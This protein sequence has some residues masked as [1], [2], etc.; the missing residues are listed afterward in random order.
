MNWSQGL[1]PAREEISLFV[2]SFQDP[3]S[4]QT[5]ISMRSRQKH[6]SGLKTDQVLEWLNF[7][8]PGEYAH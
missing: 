4:Q 3:A 8:T 1:G 6:K 7:N 2:N 5:Q